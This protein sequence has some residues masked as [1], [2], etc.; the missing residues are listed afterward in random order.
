M[1]T[2]HNTNINHNATWKKNTN[3]DL[4]SIWHKLDKIQS[5]SSGPGPSLDPCCPTTNTL[6]DDIKTALNNLDIS[7]DNLVLNTDTLEINTDELESLLTTLNQLTQ[8]END[9]SQVLLT[10]IKTNLQTIID[11][12]NQ[13]CG[14]DTIKVDV[15][16]LPQIE[17][18]TDV[19]NTST[20]VKT[21]PISIAD[22]DLACTL[23]GINTCCEV[24]NFGN[25]DIDNIPSIDLINANYDEPNLLLYVPV[26][27]P[28]LIDEVQVIYYDVNDNPITGY[29]IDTLFGTGYNTTVVNIAD[30][31]FQNGFRKVKIVY[32]L[33]TGFEAE[34]YIQ[35]F[36]TSDGG[37]KTFWHRVFS[38]QVY[39]CV[40]ETTYSV[41]YTELGTIINSSTNCLQS[42]GVIPIINNTENNGLLLN[43]GSTNFQLLF[44]YSYQDLSSCFLESIDN[45]NL[46]NLG[47]NYNFSGIVINND[48][49]NALIFPNSNLS[50]DGDSNTSWNIDTTLEENKVYEAEYILPIIDAG[51]CIAD[52]TSVK[53]YADIDYISAGNDGGA[54][55]FLTNGIDIYGMTF[56][57]NLGRSI[58]EIPQDIMPIPLSEYPNLKVVLAW[59]QVQFNLYEVYA[60]YLSNCSSTTEHEVVPVKIH[61]SSTNPIHTIID[62]LPIEQ[63]SDST[64]VENNGS[65]VATNKSIYDPSNTLL[66]VSGS[67]ADTDDNNPST[68]IHVERGDGEGIAQLAW[69]YNNFGNCPIIGAKAIMTFNLVN[70]ISSSSSNIL[71]IEDNTTNTIVGSRIIT[72]ADN[73][74][75]VTIEVQTNSVG[76]ISN[77]LSVKLFIADSNTVTNNVLEISEIT[78]EYTEQCTIPGDLHDVVP[79]KLSC[80]PANGL[81]IDFNLDYVLLG[82]EVYNAQ[83][84]YNTQETIIVNSSNS[85]YTLPVN[86]FHDLSIRANGTTC[87]RNTGGLLVDMFNGEVFAYGVSELNT[88]PAI[89]EVTGTDTILI[90]ITK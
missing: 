4:H 36:K 40:I 73:G 78:F 13:P 11:K 9:E 77:N 28:T 50:F 3:N 87:K 59:E 85:P 2:N 15:C 61:C 31:D 45:I 10:D 90:D 46:L 25:L 27:D 44:N 65:V 18:C 71:F 38:F 82:Q 29:I 22:T 30:M 81:P 47:A 60:E 55:L 56:L 8:T 48:G 12:I 69:E 67:M 37:L 84:K 57:Q 75:S 24:T 43:N 49:N 63:C 19:V 34:Y 16:N 23:L 5:L 83:P 80:L 86:Y 7:V 52:L 14:G 68:F 72:S 26:L 58:I 53:F 42:I 70:I 88:I 20:L 39:G 35:I 54:V 79:V 1:N 66:N 74:S 17:T 21:S 33:T 6:L 41:T 64:I 62:N 32:T 76:V 89:F 51:N